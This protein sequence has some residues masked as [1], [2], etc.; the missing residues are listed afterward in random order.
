VQ[1]LSEAHV[2]AVEA[3]PEPFALLCGGNRGS[4]CEVRLA[5]LDADI[6]IGL[7]VQQ[8]RRRMITASVGGHHDQAVAVFEVDQGAGARFRFFARWSSGAAPCRQ[9]RSANR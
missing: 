2:V 7:E 3:L 6:G 5:Y 1:D 9:R 8:P 4:R